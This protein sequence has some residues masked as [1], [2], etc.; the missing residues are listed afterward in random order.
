[1]PGTRSSAPLEKT[2][3]PKGITSFYSIFDVRCSVN[4]EDV[5]KRMKSH[6]EGL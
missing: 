1:M 2:V 4:K 3:V 6:H 5:L